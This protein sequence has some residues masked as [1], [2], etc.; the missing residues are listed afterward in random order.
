MGMLIHMI[1]ALTYCSCVIASEGVETSC[2]SAS[3]FDYGDALG[4]AILFFEG[5]RSGK[6]PSKQ[7]VKWRGDSALKDGQ[8]ENVVLHGL[9]FSRY[10][11]LLLDVRSSKTS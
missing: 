5:Q 4:K 8:L 3:A 6:L 10:K 2:M 11:N 9:E 7:R 1:I